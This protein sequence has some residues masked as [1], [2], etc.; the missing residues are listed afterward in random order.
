MNR[1]ESLPQIGKDVSTPAELV[2]LAREYVFGTQKK[3]AESLN[4]DQS[5]LSRYETG[6]IKPDIGY[7][8]F[9]IMQMGMLDEGVNQEHYEGISSY[10]EH[11]LNRTNEIIAR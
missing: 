8:A 7:I 5:T 2:S 9:L 6:M 11:L 3:A 10:R 1:D 4:F